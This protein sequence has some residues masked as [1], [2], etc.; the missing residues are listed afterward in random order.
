[1]AKFCTTTLTYH[2]GFR[3][4]AQLDGEEDLTHGWVRLRFQLDAHIEG[5]HAIRSEVLLISHLEAKE[6]YKDYAL[7]M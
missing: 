5:D 4:R 1:M 6:G 2:E 7:G 3:L